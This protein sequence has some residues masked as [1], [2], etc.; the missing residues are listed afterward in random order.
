[1]NAFSATTA[2][3]AWAAAAH[4]G[5]E[6]PLVSEYKKPFIRRRLLETFLGGLRLAASE[7]APLYV[8]C[9]QV[10]M[11][12]VVPLVTVMFVLLEQSGKVTLMAAIL[13]SGAVDLLYSLALQLTASR[14][15]S[16]QDEEADMS[17][18]NIASDE[19]VI[20]FDSPLGPKTWTF[21]IR[22]KKLKGGI[23]I[24]SLITGVVG[25]CCVY[26]IRPSTTYHLGPP[27]A[28]S[29]TF[30]L[31]GVLTVAAGTWPLIGG[32][33]PEPATFHPL[34]H[35]LPT[36]SRPAHML[37]CV[38]LHFLANR[39][40]YNWLLTVDA[41]THTLFAL[42]PALWLLGILPPIDAYV[43]WLLEQWLV[44]VL[45]GSPVSSTRRLLAQV[46]FGTLSLLM[47]AAL[48]SYPSMIVFAACRGF[49]LSVD[50]AW[51]VSSLLSHRVSILAGLSGKYDETHPG[52]GGAPSL[53]RQTCH[54]EL[55]LVVVMLVAVSGMSLGCHVPHMEWYE[56]VVNITWENGTVSKFPSR[57]ALFQEPARDTVGVGLLVLTLAMLLVGE[58]QKVY[59]LGL[60]RNPFFPALSPGGS[61]GGGG[62][63]G[64]SC[65][66][67]YSQLLLIGCPLLS[68][69]FV[70]QAVSA[71]L[72]L[73]AVALPET[74]GHLLLTVP[75]ARVMRQIWQFP[76]ASFLQL[77]I[78]YILDVVWRRGG[79]SS[80][81]PLGAW[82]AISPAVRMLILSVAHLWGARVLHRLSTVLL[83]LMTPFTEKKHK[84]SVNFFLL[85]FNLA[86]SPV[87]L[88]LVIVSAMLCAPLLPV[89]TLPVF[90]LGFPRPLRFWSYPVGRASNSCED[91]VYYQQLTP[92][93]ML[94][95]HAHLQAG[96]LGMTEPGEH[97]LLRW[98]DRFIWVQILESGFTYHYY[99]VKGLELQE[100]SCHTAEASRVDANF[101]RA[102]DLPES[103]SSKGKVFAALINRQA[104]H[105]LTPL[106]RFSVP[107]Y[108][109]TRNV[110][111]GVLDSPD[112]LGMVRDY[113]LKA[114]I[115]ILV[116][117]AVSRAIG[118]PQG[119]QPAP[120]SR[121]V[122]TSK[123]QGHLRNLPR[124]P[125]GKTSLPD[126]PSPVVSDQESP[127]TSLG[128]RRFSH[129]SWQSGRGSRVAWAGE[130]T[131]IPIV[132]TGDTPPP[133][134]VN[135]EEE[136]DEIDRRERRR[137]H[138]SSHIRGLVSAGSPDVTTPGS[139]I[140]GRM[141]DS[142]SDDGSSP[143]HNARR[144][145]R[146]T[147]T[148]AQTTS[149][150][151]V[152]LRVVARGGGGGGVRPSSP[153]YESPL[154]AALAPAADWMA[155]SPIETESLEEAQDA[156]PHAW[157]K[158][159]L[160]TFGHVYL[161]RLD[162]PPLP[163]QTA[164]PSTSSSSSSS[165][166]GA[167][168]EPASTHQPG[169][170]GGQGGTQGGQGDNVIQRMQYDETLEDAYR[171]LIGTCH[172]ILLG[173]DDLPP[174]P[175]QVYKTFSGEVPWS[176]HLDWLV[177]KPVLYNLVL[178][179]YRIGVKL[180]LDHTLIGGI[181]G[182]AE[183]HS[184]ME[185]YTRNWYLGPDVRV[186]EPSPNAPRTPQGLHGK[187]L[188]YKESGL[189]GPQ[190]W[191]EAVS[192]EVP[193]LF[194]LGHNAVKGVYTSHLL[195]LGE[196]EVRV[197]RLGG[198]TVRALWASL[199][200][201]LLYLTND[202]DER[203]SIQAHPGLLRNLTI[204]AADPPLGYPIFS[205]PPLRLAT[206]WLSA[207]YRQLHHDQEK[208]HQQK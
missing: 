1:M 89:F 190:S 172:L 20:E 175:S 167:S 192:M 30:S 48:P 14:L 49:V 69:V 26:Y 72:P 78:Y 40:P 176:P 147:H 159:L 149:S 97:F 207:T 166:S 196:A 161:Q 67:V 115:Y 169:S 183:L 106:T 64:G 157:F 123:S 125:R 199:V 198:E 94:A 116:D 6:S 121:P 23:I 79:V 131:G 130:Q 204:Q 154:S 18:V 51:M 182:W 177:S 137:S 108:S 112:T 179:A 96:A 144:T 93:V 113:F 127:V 133:P 128:G 124:V 75:L 16:R 135:W 46:F 90:L 138:S 141:Y 163:T 99:S 8:Y 12:S 178:M 74:F 102:F 65:L 77:S 203:Y 208:E 68:L 82:A 188:E 117:H 66:H 47:V 33:P 21:L 95:L 197:G 22:E 52:P 110:L 164:P 57:P 143:H 98:E 19:E 191:T 118:R 205:S 156:F 180:S 104:F 193:N 80:G 35:D 155:D 120:H 87:L 122:T 134:P 85:G 162:T 152:N 86:L 54:R 171:L 139:F 5:M 15:R 56:Q 186:P 59:L 136:D 62:G 119:P 100:T 4:R 42:A 9:I 105:T 37:T 195:T 88:A 202:D 103:S 109:D 153:I 107:G 2:R 58:G 43:L 146:H 101:S 76:Q 41:F 31:L 73:L 60:L 53:R 34:G 142:D 44:L 150:R 126:S 165:S 129:S 32:S 50:M 61:D 92:H 114:L 148:Y 158:F 185:D 38:L 10:A 91:S 45:G 151:V 187:A 13:I 7:D 181:T 194:A 111:T 140:P 39:H 71:E 81:G 27:W 168:S 170:K 3:L 70:H 83:F 189:W 11:F 24:S 84:N 29:L 28:A 25:G 63:G 55:V 184:H 174:S 145:N 36:L 132:R 160:S 201:E 173:P 206:T 17:Q 200:A